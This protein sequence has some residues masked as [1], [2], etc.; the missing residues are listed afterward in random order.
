MEAEAADGRTGPELRMPEV[1]AAA[2]KDRRV[3]ARAA[4]TCGD[5]QTTEYGPATQDTQEP[6]N[7]S[8]RVS[9][10]K[11]ESAV[12]DLS[13]VSFRL[14]LQLLGLLFPG[15]LDGSERIFFDLLA[16]FGAGKCKRVV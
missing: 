15:N 8:V 5:L 11:W 7:A 12:E 10:S 9:L 16:L 2:S 13:E 4:W 3:P 6:E 14:H 1:A